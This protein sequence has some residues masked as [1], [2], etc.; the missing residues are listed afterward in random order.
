MQFLAR[1]GK[2]YASKNDMSSRFSIF[3]A[4]YDRV[5]AH[6]LA[7]GENGYKMGINQF[8]DLSIEEFQTL[9]GVKGLNKPTET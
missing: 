3:S 6:N 8:S 9:Y 5:K 7:T 4:N 1:Y 2:T